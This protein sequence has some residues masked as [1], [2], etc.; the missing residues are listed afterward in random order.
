[1]AWGKSEEQKQAEAAE[2]AEAERRVAAQKAEAEAKK[3][4]A[5]Y[6]ASPVGRAEAA[7]AAGAVFFQLELDISQLAGPSSGFGSSDNTIRGTGGRPDVLG[8]V[9]DKG[10]RLE[11]VG[12]VFVE[13][14]STTSDPGVLDRAGHRHARR[15]TRHLPVPSRRVTLGASVRRRPRSAGS[16]PRRRGRG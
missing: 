4:A 16:S 2:R 9:E 12:Y 3:A 11:N 15:R 6:A 7:A 10:W 1:M 13:T 8:Q 14:G 5:E